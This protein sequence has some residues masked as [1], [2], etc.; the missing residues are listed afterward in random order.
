MSIS[1]TGCVNK[2]GNYDIQDACSLEEAL[3]LANGIRYDTFFQPNG[4]ILIKRKISNIKSKLI[5]EVN[6]IAEPQVLKKETVLDNYIIIV[7]LDAAVFEKQ[8]G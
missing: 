8:L 4:I 6:F 1:V 2:T 3:Q 5:K 7:Q